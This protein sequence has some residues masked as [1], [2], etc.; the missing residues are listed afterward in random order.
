MR[1]ILVGL[2][3]GGLL[4]FPLSVWSAFA[5]FNGDWAISIIMS[6]LVLMPFALGFSILYAVM[7]NAKM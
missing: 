5:V 7:G 6:V 3:V 2:S 1:D 4:L